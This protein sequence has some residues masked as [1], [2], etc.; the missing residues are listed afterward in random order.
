MSLKYM[1]KIYSC[2]TVTPMK[3]KLTRSVKTFAAIMKI[4]CKM[5]YKSLQHYK[6]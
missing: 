3:S 6:K 2:V 1:Y 5:Q 4:T